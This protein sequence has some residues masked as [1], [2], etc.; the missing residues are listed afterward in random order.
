MLTREIDRWLANVPAFGS[1]NGWFRAQGIQVYLRKWIIR[2]DPQVDL[3]SCHLEEGVIPQQGTYNR[4]VED[5]YQAAW[6]NGYRRVKHENV[7]NEHLV[8]RH[9]RRGLREIESN[10]PI[11]YKDL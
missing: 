8:A 3:G 6:E 5:L 10:P 1:K 4:F 9:R 2:G 7:F 11:F